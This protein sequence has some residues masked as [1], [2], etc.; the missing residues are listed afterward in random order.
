[1]SLSIRMLAEPLRSIAFGA[2]SPVYMGIGN[3]LANPARILYIQNLT[4]R[5]MFFSFDGVDDHFTLPTLGYI[6]LDV[7]TNQTT[8]Q[9][10]YISQG[11]RIYVR[12]LAGPGIPTAGEVYVSVFY[13]ANF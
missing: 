9:A 12:S 10:F 11:Q 4:D 1:M 8:P 2:I 5:L 13:G 6:L 3:G 7:T